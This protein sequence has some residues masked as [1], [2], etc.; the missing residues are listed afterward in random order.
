MAR[1]LEGKSAFVT[2]GSRGIG[3]AIVRK[4]AA[5]GLF[6]VNQ[7]CACRHIERRASG[8]S[9]ELRGVAAKPAC[10]RIGRR[11]GY[12]LVQP[13]DGHTQG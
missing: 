11:R 4:L 2:G 9:I 5:E 13:G 10:D 3:E 8:N 1:T 7:C 12:G 6:D